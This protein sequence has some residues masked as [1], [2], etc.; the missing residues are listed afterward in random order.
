MVVNIERTKDTGLRCREA[1]G[2]PLP[3]QGLRRLGAQSAT[4]ACRAGA[5]QT[6][7]VL[8]NES[9]DDPVRLVKA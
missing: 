5:R 6:L 9:M 1:P 4:E 7:G 3:L 2:R 8:V